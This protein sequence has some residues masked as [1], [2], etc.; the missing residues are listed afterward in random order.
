ME[1]A[2]TRFKYEPKIGLQPKT[3]SPDRYECPNCGTDNPANSMTAAQRGT[4][5]MNCGARLT[6]AHAWP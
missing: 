2:T 3:I 5:C 6:S 1:G 4:T